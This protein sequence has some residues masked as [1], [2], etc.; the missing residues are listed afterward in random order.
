MDNYLRFD[1]QSTEYEITLIIVSQIEMRRLLLLF[2]YCSVWTKC[3][4]C[5]MS[6]DNCFNNNN[7]II[8]IITLVLLQIRRKIS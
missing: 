4:N 6:A 8:V 2:F 1:I 7:I 3:R 5:I